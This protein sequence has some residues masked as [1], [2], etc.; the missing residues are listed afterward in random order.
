[1]PIPILQ[2]DCN[3]SRVPLLERVP[4]LLLHRPCK[5]GTASKI[6]RIIHEK[7]SDKKEMQLMKKQYTIVCPSCKSDLEVEH[8]TTIITPATKAEVEEE[9][10]VSKSTQTKLI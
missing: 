5:R 7:T 8:V 6:S 2:Q 3:T 1:M 4:V 9:I 10:R